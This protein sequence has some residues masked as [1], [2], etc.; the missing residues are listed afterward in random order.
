MLIVVTPHLF[1]FNTIF[2][3][4]SYPDL[5][6]SFL[7]LRADDTFERPFGARHS[8]NNYLFIY[9]NNGCNSFLIMF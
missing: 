7:S 3:F 6:L 9:F 1:C 8:L 2:F 5:V 4:F